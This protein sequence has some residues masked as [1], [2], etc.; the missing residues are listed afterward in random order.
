MTYTE[1]AMETA[2]ALC[3]EYKAASFDKANADDGNLG[4]FGDPRREW[5]QDRY[6]AAIKQ[7]DDHGID[8][9]HLNVMEIV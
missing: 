3:R 2:P 8:Y 9:F 6:F 7:L 5:A 4:R 1:Q